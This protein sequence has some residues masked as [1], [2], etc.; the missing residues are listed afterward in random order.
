MPAPGPDA[1]VATASASGPPSRSNVVA[2]NP[3]CSCAGSRL[4]AISRAATSTGVAAPPRTCRSGR[5][6]LRVPSPS[7]AP[8]VHRVSR[9]LMSLAA[10]P[11]VRRGAYSS[12]AASSGSGVSPVA[13]SDATQAGADAGRSPTPAVAVIARPPAEAVRLA[14]QRQ[15]DAR[16][17]VYTAVAAATVRE[18]PVANGAD[19]TASPGSRCRR[20]ASSALAASRAAGCGSS[21]MAVVSP[22]WWRAD[23]V[24][25]SPPPPPPFAPSASL[26]ATAAADAAGT[27]KA[28]AFISSGATGATNE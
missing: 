22:R 12:S 13:G 9:S 20:P 25:D 6:N 17:P 11:S 8:P 27:S 19:T 24:G 5:G 2:A 15:A 4:V 21:A 28:R 14:T 7:V 18:R 10:A 26:A 3:A 16:R 1:T 23:G